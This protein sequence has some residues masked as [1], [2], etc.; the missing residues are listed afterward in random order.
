MKF[1]FAPLEGIT[2]YILRS[3]YHA[4][5]EAADKYFIPFFT[6]TYTHKFGS[7]EM[8]E[9]LPEH[10]RGMY[11]VP[12]ILTN[13][14]DDFI[15][16]VKWLQENGYDEVNLN[17]GCPSKTV[18][19]K[20]KGSGFLTELEELDRFFEKVFQETDAK[21][22]VKTRLG[23]FDAEEYEEISK[24][25]NRYPLE[26]VILHPR[27]QEQFYKGI[28]NYEAYAKAAAESAHP[29]CYNGDVFSKTDYEQIMER[30][31]NTEQI[32]LGRGILRHPGL[33]GRL[34]NGEIVTAEQIKAYHDQILSQYKEVLY[35]EKNVLF[36][37][38]ELWF[39]L[40]ESFEE[41]KKYTKKI[42]K[43]EKIWAY[44]EAVEQLFA[45][46]NLKDY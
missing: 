17:L 24:I 35:G 20:G 7:K 11:T 39:Y 19:T 5:F 9:I 13:N 29:I 1:Y 21:I 46:C 32:M 22:S 45:N 40:G 37:M 36:K 38:K 30:F 12:Q 15:W 31:P 28:P 18:V 25:Y 14:A 23:R 41:S 34:K 43:A 27:I 4:H 10:N 2:G 42:K 44:E 6:P 3:T 8:N 26:E 16:S 33:I